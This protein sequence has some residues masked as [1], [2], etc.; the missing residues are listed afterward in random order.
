MKFKYFTLVI[1]L[2]STLTVVNFAFAAQGNQNMFKPAVFPVSS[3]VQPPVVPTQFDITGYMQNATVDPYVCTGSG[4]YIDPRLWG[5]RVTVNGVDIIIPCNTILQMPATTLTWSELFDPSL[6]P[7]GTALGTSGL[8]LDDKNMTPDSLALPAYEIH[9][10]GNI[11]KDSVTGDNQHIP[12][13]Q[14]S[15]RLKF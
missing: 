6:T 14:N 1:G 7:V 12:L 10:Q 8:A 9:I 13:R 11:V 5:G 15:C 3:T 2:M 4:T